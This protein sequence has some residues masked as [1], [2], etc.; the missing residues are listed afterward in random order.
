MIG[1]AQDAMEKLAEK[2]KAL[3]LGG[4]DEGLI[5][6]IAA[7]DAAL[8]E[9]K[10]ARESGPSRGNTRGKRIQAAEE[11]LKEAQELLIEQ[12]RLINTNETLLAL[13]GERGQEAENLAANEERRRRALLEE[14][15]IRK[16]YFGMMGAFAKAQGLSLAEYLDKVQQSDLTVD[17][18]KESLGSSTK[19]TELLNQAMAK[20]AEEAAE[21]AKEAEQAA[22][23]LRGLETI[24]DGIA[25][26]L[27]V[28][29]AELSALNREASTGI[30]TQIA[31]KRYDL[32]EGLRDAI[33]GGADPVAARAEHIRS[34]NQLTE[35]EKTLLAIE[36]ERERQS[37]ITA[38]T[39]TSGT[40]AQ[41]EETV[42]LSQAMQDQIQVFNSMNKAMEGGFMSMV[43]GTKS[44]GDSFKDMA[45]SIVAELYKVYVLQKMIGGLGQGNNAGTGILGGIQSI[46]GLPNIP[47]RASGG[48]ISGGTPY[49]V[50]EKGPE[51]IIPRNRGHVMNADLTAQALGGGDSFEQH[52]HFQFAAN[53]DDSVK[54]IIAQAMPAI[55]SASKQGVMDAR[56]RGGSMKNAFG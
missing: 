25:R 19:F 34:L 29:R 27:V 49:L 50:G 36:Q 4:V 39:A 5:N 55:V 51:L 53:G 48:S 47:G 35:Y 45:R 15:R 3:G 16:E 17:E 18:M 31:G 56:R 40:A 21:L 33:A 9:L 7:H 44:V 46:L 28:A 54:R 20:A 1:L 22:S 38:S 32:D 41:I 42:A 23:A 8:K 43:D 2:N 12:R 14:Q 52:Y 10:E 37:Q 13:E 26:G 24:G 11:K 30:A 6:A